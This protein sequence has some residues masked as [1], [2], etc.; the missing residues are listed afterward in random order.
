MASPGAVAETLIGAPWME[1]L[2]RLPLWSGALVLGYHRI[3]TDDAET[4]FNRGVVS[5]SGATFDAQLGFITQHFDVVAA[6]YLERPGSARGRRVILT[7]DDGYRDNYQVA[8]PLLRKHGVPATFFL[9]TGFLDAP[10][11]PW[12]D[13]IAWVVKQSARRALDRG[14]WLATDLLLE[15]NERAAIDELGRVYKT[16]EADQTDAFLDYC[17]DAAGTGRCPTDAAADLWMTWRMAS[18][19]LDAGM[20]IGGHTVTH[21]VLGR[22]NAERQRAEIEDCARRLR[23]ELDIRMRLFAYPFGLPSAFNGTSRQLLRAA[24][25]TLA[26]SLYGGYVRRHMADAYD[27]PRA[28]VSIDMPPAGFRAMLNAP[29]LFARW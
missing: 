14:R 20:A 29:A 3:Q 24:G 4:T 1:W 22:A 17:G 16:L 26:F 11:V 21:P 27:V 2:A 25:V 23:E 13:E 12:W 10:A 18:E 5:A 28:S 9:T 19:L 7:F 8:L 6:D 15:G